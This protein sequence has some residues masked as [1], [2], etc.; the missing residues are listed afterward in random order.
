MNCTNINY[1][2]IVAQYL[3][4]VNYIK[5]IYRFRNGRRIFSTYKI[6]RQYDFSAKCRKKRPQIC[7]RFGYAI[8]TIISNRDQIALLILRRVERWMCKQD[9]DCILRNSFFLQHSPTCLVCTIIL[10]GFWKYRFTIYDLIRL[11]CEEK[12]TFV[13]CC[14]INTVCSFYLGVERE[15]IGCKFV[16]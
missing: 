2:S 8:G 14:I 13:L 1:M 9:L 7:G 10:I 16:N 3:A 4:T 5:T 11:I 12:H 15:P 6:G